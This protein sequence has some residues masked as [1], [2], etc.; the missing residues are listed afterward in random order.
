MWSATVCPPSPRS[1]A[2]RWPSGRHV[3]VGVGVAAEVR[4]QERPLEHLLG[5]A[6]AQRVAGD[7][8]GDHPSRCSRCGS[9]APC[10]S[11]SSADGSRRRPRSATCRR[12]SGTVARRS[13]R[14]P[15]SADW[16]ATQRPSGENARLG[17]GGLGLRDRPAARDRRRVGSTM[18]SL[19]VWL[20]TWVNRMKRPSG[21]HEL[22]NLPSSTGGEPFLLARAVRRSPVEIDAVLALGGPDDR[23]RRRVT[24]AGPSRDRRRR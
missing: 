13:G 5:R 20:F 2:K 18:M 16:Y 11:C 21:D 17:L 22:A 9:R 15:D 12:A 6:G 8:D 1:M 7:V 3:V 23:R 10:R 19:P 4:L 14:A 24:T